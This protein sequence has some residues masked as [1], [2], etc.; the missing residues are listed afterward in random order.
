MQADRQGRPSGLRRAARALACCLLMLTIVLSSALSSAAH[1]CISPHTGAAGGVAF[2]ADPSS[3][4]EAPLTGLADQV[5]YCGCYH[6]GAVMPTLAV[7]SEP[8]ALVPPS[9]GQPP[10]VAPSPPATPRKPP[11]A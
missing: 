5:D 1:I 6:F 3:N 7:A 2:A 11:R 9:S 4:D 10:A 8:V